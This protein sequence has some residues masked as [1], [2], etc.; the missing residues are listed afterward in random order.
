MLG[1]FPG[2]LHAWYIIS[3]NPE[4]DH[5]YEPIADAENGRVTYYYVRHEQPV[6]GTRAKPN[7]GGTQS[8]SGQRQAA[9]PVPE[10]SRPAAQGPSTGAGADEAG[11]PPS[12]SDVVKGDNKVQ[13]QD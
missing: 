10:A 9:P 7:Y 8:G 13:S 2:L 3:L 11:A 6:T 12:Y 4:R 1:Y 5:D